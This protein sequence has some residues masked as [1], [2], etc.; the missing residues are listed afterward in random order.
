MQDTGS[1]EYIKLDAPTVT[2]PKTYM[3]PSP[4]DLLVMTP[5]NVNEAAAVKVECQCS[6]P[7][8]PAPESQVALVAPFLL[9]LLFMFWLGGLVRRIVCER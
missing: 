7:P 8:C 2:A 9:S 6:V 1:G 3:I 5:A 4:V